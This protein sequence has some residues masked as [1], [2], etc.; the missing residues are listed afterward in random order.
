MSAHCHMRARVCLSVHHLCIVCVVCVSV[1]VLCVR[2]PF[3]KREATLC[4][5]NVGSQIVVAMSWIHAFLLLLGV[6]VCVRGCG[7]M[8][9]GHLVWPAPAPARSEAP[10][11]CKVAKGEWRTCEQQQK[12][13][14]KGCWISAS[15]AGFPTTRGLGV[16]SVDLVC[17]F[18]FGGG[19][20]SPVVATPRAGGACQPESNPWRL[21]GLILMF[22]KKKTALKNLV[23]FFAFRCLPSKNSSQKMAPRSRP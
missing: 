4:M 18:F 23:F 20:G 16:G 15:F 22:C 2:P 10:V 9:C 19:G 7:C 3:P 14:K 11:T 8:K 6:C 1:F 12:K 21:G 13:T 5:K 17:L